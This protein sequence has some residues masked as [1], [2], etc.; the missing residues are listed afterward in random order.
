MEGENGVGLGKI[1]KDSDPIEENAMSL[2]PRSEYPIPEE[3][4]RVARMIFPKGNLYMQRYDTFGM[5]FADEDFRALFPQDGQPGLSLIRL[6]LV[7]LL[8]YAEG[9]SDWQ[10]ADAVRTESSA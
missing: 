9:L 2:F 6:S 5:L 4:A 3:T 10:A 1:K 8:R 7:C